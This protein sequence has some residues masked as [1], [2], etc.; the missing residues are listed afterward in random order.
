M[1]LWDR[2]TGQMIRRSPGHGGWVM[3]VTFSPDGRR[4][5]SGGEDKVIRL[6][7]LE[8]GALIRELRGHTDWVFKVAFSPDGRRAYSSSG[9]FNDGVWRDGTDSA[10]RVWDVETGRQVC[11]LEA[12]KGTVWGL[13]VSSDGRRLLSAG[14]A[15]ILWDLETGAEIRRFLGHADKVANVAFLPDGRRAVSSGWDGTFRLWNLETGDQLDCLGGQSPGQG[16][17]VAVSSDGRQL[18]T[19]NWGGRDV[20]LWDVESGKQLNRVGWENVHPLQGCF[21]PDGLRAVWTG[22]DGVIRMYRLNKA[23]QEQRSAS[24]N[25]PDASKPQDLAR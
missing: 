14:D 22:S 17:C 18:L 24:P 6:W 7:D 20:R 16:T 13:A 5:L 9:G 1:I 10:I 25:A 12:H 3:S 15:I 2:E 19:S 4:A 8:S 11:K 23:A 21:T